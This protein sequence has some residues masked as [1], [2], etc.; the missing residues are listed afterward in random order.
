MEALAARKGVIRDSKQGVS[1]IAS[2]YNKRRNT[3]KLLGRPKA[4]STKCVR[5]SLPHGPVQKTGVR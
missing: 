5:E 2:A 3:A 1:L 4:L